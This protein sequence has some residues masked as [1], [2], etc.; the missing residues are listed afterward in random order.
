VVLANTDYDKVLNSDGTRKFDDMLE[1]KDEAQFMEDSF[2]LLNYET[3]VLLNPSNEEM[4]DLFKELFKTVKQAIKDDKRTLIHFYYTGHGKI[5]DQTYMV[6]NEPDFKKSMFPLE[7][8]LRTLSLF[9]NTMVLALMDCCREQVKA[10]EDVPPQKL[11]HLKNSKGE[12]V[13]EALYTGLKAANESEELFTITFGCKPTYGVM[14][15]S[16]LGPYYMRHM[17]E[18]AKENNGRVVLPLAFI[19][20]VDSN[21]QA[22]TTIKCPLQAVI[23]YGPPKPANA[24]LMLEDASGRKWQYTGEM[25]NYRANGKGTAISGGDVYTGEWVNSKKHGQGFFRSGNGD[26]YTGEFKND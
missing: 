21:K 13:D 20:F 25:R 12:K 4:T 24:E 15:G 1:A 14:R 19:D 11:V 23:N 18:F 2:K 26:V 5:K 3:R 7:R 16:C 10:G 8:K 9:Q 17:E 6:L 22:E